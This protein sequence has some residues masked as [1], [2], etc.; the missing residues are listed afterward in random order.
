[1]KRIKDRWKA[2]FGKNKGLFNNKEV[3]LTKAEKDD[4]KSALTEIELRDR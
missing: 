1:M 2:I 3:K 4:I